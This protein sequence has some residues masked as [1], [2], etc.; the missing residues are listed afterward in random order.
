M[1][2]RLKLLLLIPGGVPL[3]CEYLLISKLCGMTKHFQLK[4]GER[5]RETQ[6]VHKQKVLSRGFLSFTTMKAARKWFRS[7]KLKFKATGKKLKDILRVWFPKKDKGLKKKAKQ[8]AKKAKRVVNKVAK[9]QVRVMQSSHYIKQTI[10]VV[11]A[12]IMAVLPIVTAFQLQK[13]AGQAQEAKQTAQEAKETVQNF[14]EKLTNPSVGDMVG[15]VVG[16]A[17]DSAIDIFNWIK[18]VW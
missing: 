12:I 6:L 5:E 1:Q 13:I 2:K 16:A 7:L 8:M 4:R 3:Q 17:V 15:T 10:V 18:Q 9:A 14:T 11:Y